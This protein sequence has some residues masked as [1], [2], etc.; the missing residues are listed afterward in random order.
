[1]CFSGG[2]RRKPIY[3]FPREREQEKIRERRR[4]RHRPATRPP[5]PFLTPLPRRKAQGIPRD[6]YIWI[7]L[8][9]RVNPEFKDSHLPASSPRPVAVPSP[10]SPSFVC[11]PRRSASS[12]SPFTIPR[13]DF[14][15]FLFLTS[16]APRETSG[17]GSVCMC[18]FVCVCVPPTKVPGVKKG[19]RAR[20]RRAV[21]SQYSTVAV[22]HIVAGQSRASA[23][24]PSGWAPTPSQGSQPLGHR[25]YKVR[26]LW[27]VGREV[28]GLL[29]LS[30]RH[31]QVGEKCAVK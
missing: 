9:P 2:S 29:G 31:H 12:V 1:M 14:L 18:V 25:L 5:P 30:T 8:Q 6:V 3:V 23:R 21:R 24:F 20:C 17:P 19:R 22:H 10:I 28:L 26:S 11:I 15:F 13:S 27:R 4:R 7:S 16:S